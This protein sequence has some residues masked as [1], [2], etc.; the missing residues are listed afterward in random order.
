MFS[1]NYISWCTEFSIKIPRLGDNGQFGVQLHVELRLLFCFL[2]QSFMFTYTEF[3][4]LFYSVVRHSCILAIRLQ[5]FSLLLSL[6]AWM[7]WYCQQTATS[8]FILLPKLLMRTACTS[9]QI[10]REICQWPPFLVRC[11]IWLLHFFC[12][13]HS[14][15]SCKHWQY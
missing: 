2:M 13:S 15:K 11:V 8:L 3:H 12:F 5:F 10:P 6:L 1:Q 7:I 9:A 14:F 4:M